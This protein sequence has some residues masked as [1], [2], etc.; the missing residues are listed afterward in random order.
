[1]MENNSRLMAVSVISAIILWVFVV[2][3]ENPTIE[4]DFRNIPIVYKNL[5]SL[6]NKDMDLVGD[7]ETTV[8]IVLSGASNNFISL[9]PSDLRAEVD[10]KDFDE[11][12]DTI[13]ISFFYPSNLTLVES[14][15]DQVDVRVEKIISKEVKI[16]I[17]QTGTPADNFAVLVGSVIPESIVVE[18]ARSA[19]DRAEKA[20]AVQD[21]AEITSNTTKNTPIRIIDSNGEEVSGLNLSQN[22]I[23]VSYDV[24][25]IAQVPIKLVVEN[26]LDESLAVGSSKLSQDMV[27]IM[28]PSSSEVVPEY[29]ETRP[30]DL[31]KVTESGSYKLDLII[32][33]GFRLRD[34]ENEISIVYDLSPSTSKSIV[35][36]SRDVEVRGAQGL[37]PS[38][39]ENIV[40][41]VEILGTKEQLDSLGPAN[42]KLFVDASNLNSGDHYLPIKVED[43]EA[44]RINQVSPSRIRVRLVD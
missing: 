27:S 1:M 16:E 26:D 22:F 6:Y 8:D 20:I 10:M 14:S 33:E 5:D 24:Y 43:L 42:I 13:P 30:F 28:V 44:G 9:R 19:V 18:G 34:T 35:K 29:I 17:N 39:E 40:I 12:S 36:N 21:M 3:T 23:N 11:N 25:K 7:R 2:A 31:S 32:P 4:R 15:K 37:S 38:V 41:N